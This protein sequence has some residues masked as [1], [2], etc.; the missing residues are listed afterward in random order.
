[1]GA[2]SYRNRNKGKV[3]ATGRNRKANWEYRFFGAP[4]NGTPQRFEKCGFKTKEEA[5]KAGTL[6]FN[7]YMSAGS[8]FEASDMSYSDCLHSWMENY[9]AIN[10]NI[11]TKEGYET[12]I[13]MY[14]EPALGRYRLSALRRDAIQSFINKM[15][16]SRFSRNTLS[17]L[18][19]II[20]SSLRYA[21]RQGW[22]QTNPAD[23]IDLPRTSNCTN[24]RHKTRDAIPRDV[25]QR[26]FERFPEGHPAHLPL[27][28]A[29]H[30][31]MRLG[32]VFGL[33]WD[34]VD[35]DT[36]TIY[37]QHQAQ[38]YDREAFWRLVPPKYNSI[39]PVRID[40]VMWGLLKREKVRQEAGRIAYGDKYH[41]L[42]IDE[43]N[44]LNEEQRGTPIDMVNRREDG[45]YVQ[46]RITQHTST[47]IKTE[48]NYPEFDFHSLR[49]THATELCEAGVNLKEIQRRLGH[50]TLEVTN[51]R[52]IHATELMEK[53]SLDIMNGM[54]DT[55][56][57]VSV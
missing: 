2:I 50:K 43:S 9:V 16:F 22:I 20:T 5:V 23:D 55:P 14:I 33:T 1:M 25:M 17:S 42:Y 6:A 28:L 31:G 52:Y 36:G 51:R 18:L 34:N 3:D 56:K 19:G 11:T 7:E 49:H 37:I 29:Y 26:I 53:Q 38:R 54:Y 40:S 57:A 44:F 27:M 39:R 32:E 12:R 48:L 46:A 10:C 30:C 45:S 8:V 4:I 21:R 13:S 47:V 24:Q 41:Q 35:L 15:F